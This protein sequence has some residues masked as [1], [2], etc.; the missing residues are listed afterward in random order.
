[1]SDKS[2][3]LSEVI[4]SG[5]A[6]RPTVG[7]PKGKSTYFEILKRFAK[8]QRLQKIYYGKINRLIPLGKTNCAM[9]YWG[10]RTKETEILV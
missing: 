9:G 3:E 8:A 6:H 4:L 5:L 1:M 7:F 10:W 2:I